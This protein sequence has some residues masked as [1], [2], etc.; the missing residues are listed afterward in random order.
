MAAAH[1]PHRAGVALV[2]VA[3]VA[4]NYGAFFDSCTILL[5]RGLFGGASALTLR[6]RADFCSPRPARC[7]Q[8]VAAGLRQ[9][10]ARSKS[11]ALCSRRSAE[12]RFGVPARTPKFGAAWIS[13]PQ[14]D[15]NV[16]MAP[17]RPPD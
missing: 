1:L 3:A 15:I 4:L 11:W 10:F 16:E 14:A 8:P 6:L 5:W 13:E 17:D 7:R 2:V 9:P 12:K